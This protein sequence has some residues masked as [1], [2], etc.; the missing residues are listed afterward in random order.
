M[1]N[2]FEID[3][4]S[5]I[6]IWVFK[7]ITLDGKDLTILNKI[8]MLTRRCFSIL[9]DENIPLT[10]ESVTPYEKGIVF[11]GRGAGDFTARLL[12]DANPFAIFHIRS[13]DLRMAG[14]KKIKN[15]K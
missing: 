5:G 2:G 7:K 13:V 3:K 14:V 11:R 6:P 8:N 12:Y 9:R 15:K 4:E 1:Q 10:M